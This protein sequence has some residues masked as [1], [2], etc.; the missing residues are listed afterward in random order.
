M[1]VDRE[2][3]VWLMRLENAIDGGLCRL[4]FRQRALLEPGSKPSGQQQRILIPKRDAQVFGE[5]CDHFTAGLRST[6]LQTRQMSCRA[7]RRQREIGLRHAPSLTPTSKEH[8][9]GK[10][11]NGHR[12]SITPGVEGRHDLTGQI[13]Y[14]E[15]VTF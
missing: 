7:F 4:Q 8:A 3:R 12:S 10:L 13:T 9:E 6:S 14:L 15:T 1:P 11:M 2:G 5:P